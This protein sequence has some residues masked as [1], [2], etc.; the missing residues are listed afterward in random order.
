MTVEQ[1]ATR[2][3]GPG[4]DDERRMLEVVG[5]GSID[6]L[7]DAAI[8]EVIRWHGT[9]DLP[10]P[11]TEAETIAELRALAARNTVAVSMIGLGYHGTHTP[12]V[13][14]RNVLEDP[15]WYT[16]YT[17]YQPEI[18]QGRLEAL[19][20][21]QTM[22][23]DLTGLAT[24][25]ASM[26]DEGTAAAE[27]MTLARRASKSKSG[28]YV[29]DADALPQTIAVITSRAVPLGID[30][31]V[32]DVQR[33]ELPAEFFGLHLQYPGASGAVRDHAGLVQAAHAV[34]ALVTVAADLL[35]LTLL[36]APG[37]IGADIA[38]GTTQ[39]FGVP[40]GFGGPHAG[41]LAVR[42]GLERMLPGRLVGVSR[43]ADGNPAYRLALQTREQHIRREKATSN[44]CTAQVLLAVMA[45]MYAVYHGPDGLRDIATRTHAMAARLAAGLRAG[46]VDVADVAFFDTVTATVPGAAAEVVAAAA[47]RGVNLRLVDADRVGVS[48]DETTTDAHLTQVWA[49]FGVPAFD[50][51]VDAAL[52]VDLTRTS[53]FLTHPVFRSH[54]SETA[55]LRYLRRLSDF[56][57]ALDR[58]MIP[59]GSC[60]MK[61]NA[62]TE[63][64]PVS[65]AEFANIHPFAPDAQTVGYREMIGQLESWLA[66][67][68]GYDAVSVQPNA[69][70]QG[71]LAG[72]LAIRS[73]HASRGE[74]HRD[75]CLIPSSAHGTNAASAVMAGMRVVVVACDDNG[76]V[77]LVDLDAKI[78]K[79]RDALAAIMVTYPS[80]HGVYET[81]IASLC[82]KV[83]DA[84]GQVYVDGANLNALVG[85]AK[86]G[87]FGADVSHLNL[88]KTFC[89]PHGGGGPGV[90]PVAVRAHLAP[91]LPGDPL[92][93]HVDATP[94]IS[95]AKYGSAGILPIPWAYL[96]MMGAEGLT[97]A[98]GVAVL[99]A[100][101]VAAR[102]RG[103]FPVLYAGNKGLVAHECILDLRPLT[104]TTGVSVDD[105]AKRLI[106]YG[107]HAPTM[108]FPVAGTLMVEPT[109]SEDLAELDRFCDAMIAIRAEIEQVG[110]GAWPAGDNPLANA[111]H[112]AA[113]VSGDEWSHAY[114]R[115][116]GAYPAGVD[117]AGKYWPPVRRIDG[118]YGDRN[119]VCSCPSPEAFED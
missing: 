82:A 16:A 86:P 90:G 68:T 21:F 64:E 33:D 53:D 26:L 29:V 44:I 18:S 77:D 107:F 48:C 110:S 54:H 17:P 8:P 20:N 80:T 115:S 7:M 101:Y 50:G 57:Y 27:A 42:S 13:I 72:L 25:N 19:L 60:T 30:V 74:T 28:V 59:L 106:D 63:M 66:E 119:L 114:P 61:L 41:Y 70:S 10:D 65:W 87:K 103:Y 118:A 38:A 23:T 109:E 97:R 83:H 104:K 14:R 91:F 34:G 35:A 88:H 5:H 24:A 6:E 78:D 111:P 12:A 81:G 89:I 94:A 92:G 1:F 108:S 99:A 37:E 51:D 43:D 112:T 55:M 4:P 116:V 47:D 96:R 46:G 49:A 85:F 52:P 117:R 102:L 76:N 105:V 56:D 75:V 67:V 84:G 62:T 9:L 22:V 93:A 79:H 3:I 95:A 11:A 40:M 36:R 71:E 100:N 69:G 15:A 31:R 2:H 45:G 98:T 73:Y 113:M 32:L 39:R 58:G